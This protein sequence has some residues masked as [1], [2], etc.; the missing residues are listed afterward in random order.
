MLSRISFLNSLQVYELVKPRD[1]SPAD[2]DGR[3]LARHV[4]AARSPRRAARILGVSEEEL[5][6]AGGTPKS[7]FAKSLAL[8]EPKRVF[9]QPTV[10]PFADAG[11]FYRG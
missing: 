9:W 7:R 6:S 10:E 2:E 5:L 3:H 4:V 1:D 11:V 8:R